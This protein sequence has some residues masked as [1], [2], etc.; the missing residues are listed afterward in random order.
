[1]REQYNHRATI[2]TAFSVGALLAVLA[3]GCAALQDVEQFA[4]SYVKGYCARPA[5]ERAFYRQIINQ[6][7]AES[8]ASITVTCPGD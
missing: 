4:I 7:L 1:M 6:E 5:A 2:L 3:S 8:G